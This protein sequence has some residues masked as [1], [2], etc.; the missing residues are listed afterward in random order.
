MVKRREV[1]RFFEERGF[2]NM[3]GTNHDR[4][5]HPDGRW[6]ILGRH[7]EIPNRMFEEMKKQAGLK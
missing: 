3:G 6:T 5:Q 7:R 4:L 1:E 2:E